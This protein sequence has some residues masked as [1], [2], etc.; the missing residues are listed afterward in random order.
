MAAIGGSA[1]GASLLSL[2]AA[3]VAE[4]GRE[5]VAAPRVKPLRSTKTLI[6]QPVLSCT[7]A[8]RQE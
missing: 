6:V 1:A 4:A 7:V 8:K 3:A 5:I 2:G